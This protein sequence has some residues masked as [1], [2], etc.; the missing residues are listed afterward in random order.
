M[1]SSDFSDDNFTLPNV[2][3]DCDSP[4]SR[5]THAHGVSES[6]YQCQGEYRLMKRARC[7][8]SPAIA[9]DA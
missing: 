5:L 1:F 8:R 7:H 4:V 3:F 2:L 9:G 6:S